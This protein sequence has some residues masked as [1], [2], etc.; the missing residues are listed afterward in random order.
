MPVK[1]LDREFVLLRDSWPVMDARTTKGIHRKLEGCTSEY[2]EIDDI[3]EI[4]DV[5]GD[6]VVSVG[7]FGLE[8][9]RVVDA[10]YAIEACRN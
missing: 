3:N 9:S 10:L 1:D 6:V 2:L 5:G 7:F 8:S 4:V